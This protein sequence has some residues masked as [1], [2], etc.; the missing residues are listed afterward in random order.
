[1]A[2]LTWRNVDGVSGSGALEGIRAFNQGVTGGLDRLAASLGNFQQAD[3][4]N[5]GNQVMQRALQIND[6]EAYQ[7]ALR[8][9]SI[10]GGIDPSRLSAETLAGLGSRANDLVR[11]AAQVQSTAQNKYNFGRQVDADQRLEAADPA[12][13]AL[14][15]AQRSGDPRVVQQA[16]QDPALKGLRTDQIQKLMADTQAAEG[17]TLANQGAMTSNA[18]ASYTLSN[19]MEE[20]AARKEASD[21]LLLNR[22][23]SGS[24]EQYQR[25]VASGINSLSPSARRLVGAQI[26]LGFGPS[27]QPQQAQGGFV[28]SAPGTAGTRQGSSYDA[29][30]K[31][32]PTSR[33]ITSMSISDVL[34]YQA[35]MI[36]DPNLGHSPVG[37]YQINKATLEEYGPKALGPDW[38]SMPMS[39]ENQEKIAEALYNDRKGGDLTKTWAALNNSKVGYYKDI[40]WSQARQEIAGKEVAAQDAGI[41]LNPVQEIVGQARIAQLDALNR[42]A[43]EAS[44]TLVNGFDR[45]IRDL[46]PASELLPELTGKGGAFEGADKQWLMQHIEQAK[47]RMAA[48]G[49]PINDATVIEALKA[50]VGSGRTSGIGRGWDQLTSWVGGGPTDND[51]KTNLG[52]NTNRLNQI[53]D[54]EFARGNAPE[55]VAVAEMRGNFAK[56]IEDA[57]KAAQAANAERVKLQQAMRTNPSLARNLPAL[58]QAEERA[59]ARV[60]ELTRQLQEVDN[61]WAARRKQELA[62]KTTG[63]TSQKSDKRSSERLQN[64]LDGR[65]GVLG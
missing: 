39:P 50:S 35:G 32:T 60:L 12:I 23:S 27:D 57:S 38:K 49:V 19:R 42:R 29:T 15:F 45:S 14:A 41:D 9:G 33:P 21:Y 65:S 34:D 31:F 44:G 30:F 17:R 5:L 18:S 13:R 25:N 51:S 28:P 4:A 3:Q 10:L 20:D 63:T 52:I 55:R 6:P 1:M 8:D 7:A 43:Q 64:W 58:V 2:Q 59:Q 36:K 48:Q 62:P 16:L 56:Q 37:R 61:Q 47:D 22:M 54:N 46:R 24:E 40:P 26:G 53:L 11:Q